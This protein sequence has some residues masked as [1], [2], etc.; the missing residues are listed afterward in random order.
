MQPLVLHNPLAGGLL[1]GTVLLWDASEVMLWRRT[2]GHSPP[3]ATLLLILLLAVTTPVFAGAAANHHLA[4]LPGSLWW[5]VAAGLALIWAGVALRVWAVLTLGRF[6]KM[7]VVV[8]EGHRVIDSGPY[9]WL[10][11]PS[12]LGLILCFTG[13]GLAWGDWVSLAIMLGCSLAVLLVRIRV[14]ERTLLRELG[15]EYAAY[16][17]R[18]ARLVPGVF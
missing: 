8:Q 10:R 2:R 6:F 15:E 12:Y 14:E 9:R 17:R 7:V 5:P 16:S 1:F 3:D 13:F 4:P 11:H 18:T